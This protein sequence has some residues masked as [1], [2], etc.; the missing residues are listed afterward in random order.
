MG[1]A[2]VMGCKLSGLGP[3]SKTLISFAGEMKI[4]A[5]MPVLDAGCGYGRNAAALAAAGI[6]VVCADRDMERLSA[7]VRL[8]P[9]QIAQLMPRK[10]GAGHLYPV[11]ADLAPSLWT[12]GENCFAG[13]V[14]VHFLDVALFPTFQSSLMGGGF[15]Y[16][17]TFGGHGGNYLDLPK[18]GHVRDLLQ[19]GFDLLF[20][21]EK[22]VGPAGYDAVTV[23]LFARKRS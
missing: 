10:S 2:R 14:C 16:I 3:A 21:R 13:I 18:A 20:Y 23:K 8:A 11:R 4:I 7:L 9:K 12:F 5:N 6:S 19:A 15:L 1:T 17:E 22:R